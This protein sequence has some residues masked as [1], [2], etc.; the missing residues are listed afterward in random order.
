MS[1]MTT[2]DGT[3]IYKDWGEGPA[4]AFSHGCPDWVGEKVGATA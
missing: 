3:E 1:T 2:K 4:V